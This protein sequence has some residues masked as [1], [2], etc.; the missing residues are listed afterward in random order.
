VCNK[1]D[2]EQYDIIII[3]Q[4]LKGIGTCEMEGPKRVTAAVQEFHTCIGKYSNSKYAT[5]R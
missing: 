1:P 2:N 3:A 4:S 5:I